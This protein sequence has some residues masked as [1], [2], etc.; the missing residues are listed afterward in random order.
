MF[1]YRRKQLNITQLLLKAFVLK[2]R[3]FAIFFYKDEILLSPPVTTIREGITENSQIRT[4]CQGGAKS[5][6]C[7]L[8]PWRL[9]FRAW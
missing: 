1:P 8:L 2:M 3:Y 7:W 5:R 4:I 6:R 9:V